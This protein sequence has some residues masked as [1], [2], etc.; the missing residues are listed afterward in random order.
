MK[1][2]VLI[3]LFAIVLSLASGL[4]FLTRDDRGSPRLLTALKVRVALSATLIGF[5]VLSYFMGWLLPAP[6]AG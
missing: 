2:V 1:F 6:A 5:L 3:L 4:F